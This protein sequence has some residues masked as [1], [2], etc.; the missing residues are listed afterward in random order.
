VS[1]DLLSQSFGRSKAEIAVVRVDQWR[2]Y[3]QTGQVL[4][5]YLSILA[6]IRLK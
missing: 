1:V 4:L 3:R 5:I 2:A 6:E